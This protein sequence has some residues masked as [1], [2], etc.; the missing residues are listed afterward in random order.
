MRSAGDASS[1]RKALTETFKEWLNNVGAGVILGALIALASLGPG[2]RRALG[3]LYEHAIVPPLFWCI[4]TSAAASLVL[5]SSHKHKHI[6]TYLSVPLLRFFAHSMGVSCGLI[7]VLSWRLSGI[8]ALHLSVP[9][10][11]VLW[12]LTAVLAIMAGSGLAAH[13]HKQEANAVTTIAAYLLLIVSL[14]GVGLFSVLSNDF[15]AG[16]ES[17]TGQAPQTRA[18]P[19]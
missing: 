19:H 7:P 10:L 16:I 14:A 9:A 18:A 3:Q 6:T 1:N 13:E 8:Q 17:L 15:L 12:A 2:G 5:F 11:S 4:A